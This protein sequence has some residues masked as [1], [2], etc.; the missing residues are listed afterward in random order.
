MNN[1]VDQQQPNPLGS[2][3]IAGAPQASKDVV[4]V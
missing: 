3:A 2:V 1:N 4:S